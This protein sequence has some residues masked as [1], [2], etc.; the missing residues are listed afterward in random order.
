M[1]NDDGAQFGWSSDSSLDDPCPIGGRPSRRAFLQR[2]SLTAGALA[3]GLGGCSND[4]SSG[5]STTSEPPRSTA[6]SGGAPPSGATV[7]PD[8]IAAADL[9]TEDEIFGWVEE[10]FGHGIRRTGYPADEWA[11]EWVAERFRAMGLT[12]VHAEPFTAKRW[13]PGECT[14]EITPAGGEVRTVA[15]FPLPFSAPTEGVELQLV[16]FDAEAPDAVAGQAAL[17]DVGLI[18]VPADMMA[19]GGSA[20]P[21]TD[22]V[23]DPDGTL[24]GSGHLIPFST[25]ILHVMEPAMEAGAAAFIGALRDYPGDSYEYF[26]PY[27]AVDRPIPG[28]WIN[29]SAAAELDRDLA[30]GPVQVRLVLAAE[31]AEI[32]THN[33]VGDLEGAD[34]EVVMIAS[35]HDGPWA[36]AVEDGSGM[37]LVLAQAQY[38]AK[39]PVEER[40]HR[41]RFVMQGGHM[42]GGAGLL[43]YIEA[44][45]AEL[46]D[47][48]LEVHLEHAALETEV[49]DGE[50]VATD[51]PV[52]RW[53]FTSR[54][55]ALEASVFDALEG[56]ELHRS[57]VVA[58]D[59][60]GEQPPT[61]GAMYHRE[62]VPMVNF[63]TAPFY[64]FDS[65]DTLDKVDR[66]NLVPLTRA[67]IRIVNATAG[68]SAA[69]MRAGAEEAPAEG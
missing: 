7:G 54:I 30:A 42:S 17:V 13:E 9:P 28:V 2:A 61:D 38:W 49:V 62:G 24:Q 3:L 27:D 1:Q 48:V 60:F 21:D 16:H 31:T 67:T 41:L 35:H 6:S 57:M 58:P 33:I 59:A 5:P 44:H 8:G 56:E 29:D 46:A 47:V 52:P 69:E 14:L 37:A 68:V 36:S 55:P 19:F 45:R 32:E 25:E 23:V 22:R 15:C 43:A 34:D 40:P 50:V 26:V 66:A 53:F 18:E 20:P 51:V 65:M 4:D 12:D 10:I 64:L 63:L 11:E 39:R